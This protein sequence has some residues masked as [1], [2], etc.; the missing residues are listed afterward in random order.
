MKRTAFVIAGLL[1]VTAC[2]K[3]TES[4]SPP[5][6]SAEQPKT[7]NDQSG[8]AAPTEQDKAGAPAE[9]GTAVGKEEVTVG[10]T[11]IDDKGV[12]TGN[13]K[14]DKNGVKV[15]GTGVTTDGKNTS[16]GGGVQVKTGADGKKKVN[17]GGVQVGY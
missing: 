7:V 17:V 3:S 8:A 6:A 11:K 10:N 1:A 12:T 9:P 13:S 2:Q 14:V 15:G 4:S 16:I 5:A